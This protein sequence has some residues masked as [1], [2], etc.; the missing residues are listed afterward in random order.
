MDIFRRLASDRVLPDFLLQV[1]KIRGTNQF[2]IIGCFMVATSLVLIL[3]GDTETLSGVYTYAFLGLMTLFGI[4]CMLLKFKR[5]D[6]PR[7]VIAPWWSC[8]LGVSVVAT[9][10]MGNLL[11]D[12]TILTYFALYFI[13]VLAVVYI[14][15]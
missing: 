2:I 11:G 12:P 4:G 8:I 10:F 14:M 15:F 9:T 6:I 1:N 7:T 5:A 13:A 3:H